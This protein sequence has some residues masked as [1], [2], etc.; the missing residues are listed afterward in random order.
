MKNQ[1]ELMQ[2]IIDS[3]PGV[4]VMDEM[5]SLV[6]IP[7]MNYEQ[8]AVGPALRVLHS[9]LTKAD[10]NQFWEGLEK[11]LTPDGNILWLCGEHRKPYEVKPLVLPPGR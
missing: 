4:A 10:P 8:Q 5:S 9:F 7:N 11:T 2:A 1:I 3:L 6:T